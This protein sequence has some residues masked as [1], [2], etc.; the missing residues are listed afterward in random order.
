[1]T[2]S[3]RPLP[4]PLHKRSSWNFR[5]KH[6][7]FITLYFFI[8][9]LGIKGIC[10]GIPNGRIKGKLFYKPSL[11]SCC[12]LKKTCSVQKHYTSTLRYAVSNSAILRTAKIRRYAGIMPIPKCSCKIPN[13]IGINVLPTYADAI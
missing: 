12:I 8:A 11:L 10:P 4:F 3:F 2:P 6:K 13:T 1:M 7:I 9:R 5:I